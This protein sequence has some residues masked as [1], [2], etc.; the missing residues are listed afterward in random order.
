MISIYA[1][2]QSI[3]MLAETSEKSIYFYREAGNNI[4]F[5]RIL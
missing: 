1:E 4:N 3:I 5:W 2:L